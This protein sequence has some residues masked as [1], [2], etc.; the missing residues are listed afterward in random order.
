MPYRCV[1]TLRREALQSGQRAQQASSL[2]FA[3]AEEAA[4]FG[5]VIFEPPQTVESWELE[6]VNKAPNYSYKKGKLTRLLGRK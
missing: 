4:A 2:R 5:R 1:I 3:L 6:E